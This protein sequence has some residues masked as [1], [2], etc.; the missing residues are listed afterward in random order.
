MTDDQV[1]Y[2]IL[3]AVLCVGLAKLNSPRPALCAFFAGL[4]VLVLRGLT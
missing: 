2:A 1:A 3:G 4:S